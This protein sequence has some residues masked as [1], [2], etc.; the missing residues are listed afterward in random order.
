MLGFKEQFPPSVNL[1]K[2]A[3]ELVELLS[4]EQQK[5]MFKTPVSHTVNASLEFL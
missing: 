1:I 4:N 3:T 2:E 5:A